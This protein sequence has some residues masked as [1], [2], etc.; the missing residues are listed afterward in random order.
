MVFLIA[1]GSLTGYGAQLR[2]SADNHYNEYLSATSNATE[3]H[4]Q[5]LREDA[6]SPTFLTVGSVLLLPTIYFFQKQ[7]GAQKMLT[8]SS[9]VGEGQIVYTNL[10]P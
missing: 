8:N 2:S 6:Q 1:S 7:I 9:I 4:K 10:K 3:L 5:I